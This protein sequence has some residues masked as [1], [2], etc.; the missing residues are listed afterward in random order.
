M[1]KRSA[2]QIVAAARAKGKLTPGII[3][4]SL[5]SDFFELHGDRATGDDLALRTGIAYFEELPVTIVLSDKGT[6]LKDQQEKHFG[7]PLPAGYRKVLRVAKQ[8][9]K[10]NRPLLAFVNTAGA[11][12][13]K[14]AEEKG[15][16][17]ALARC[18]LELSQIK[19]PFI[20]FIY[21]EGGSGGA[22]AL[23]CGDRVY[24]TT[25][26]I[27][28]ILSPEGFATILWKDRTQADKAAQIMRL[29]PEELVKQQV[30]EGVVL[31][32]NSHQKTLASFKKI[33]HKEL[34]TLRKLTPERL[35][36]ERYQRF[37]KF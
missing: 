19:V 31:E 6:D 35:L 20:T 32:T 3:I 9:E 8:A 34:I 15:Q 33:L 10:F 21:G 25:D 27:Y 28:S 22:L 7:S 4:N 5:F 1:D 2:A 17:E 30:I 14:E 23:A 24:M 29:T 37:R 12:P 11:Y 13:G 18:L 16:G 26:S 36:D